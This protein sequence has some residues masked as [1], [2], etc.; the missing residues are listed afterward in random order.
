MKKILSVLIVPVVISACSFGNKDEQNILNVYSNEVIP[1]LD[2]MT[3]SDRYSHTAA[4]QIYEGL[5][6]YHYLKN[7]FEIYPVLADGMP[8]VSNKGLTYTIKLK[9]GV[10]FS[11]DQAFKTTKGKG[12]ELTADDFIYSI[13]RVIVS[14]YT[15]SFFFNS[16]LSDIIVGLEDFKKSASEKASSFSFEQEI[17]GMKALDK[18]TIQFKLKRPSAYFPGILTRPNAFVVAKE[19]VEYY[20]PDFKFHPVGSGPFKMQEWEKETKLT[21]VRNPNYHHGRYPS[22]GAS[23]DSEKG[24]LDD[25]GKPVPFL[26]KIVR[27]ILV[28]EQP[29]WLNFNRGLLDI[30]TLDKDSYYDAFPTGSTLSENLKE[31]GVKVIKT[32]QLDISYYCFNMT[33]NVVGKNKY[34][35]QAISLAYDGNKHNALFFNNQAYVA[36]W[37]LPPD[38]F[39][40]DASYKNPY[41]QFNVE[42]AKKLMVKAGFPGGKRLPP[43]TMLITDSIASKQTGEYFAKSL[44]EIGI[45]VNLQPMNFGLLL[46]EVDEGRNFHVAAVQWRADLPFPEDF[47]RIFYSKA[48]SPG[49]NHSRFSNAEYDKLFERSLQLA[50]GPEKLRLLNRMRDIAVEQAAIIPLINPVT[51]TLTQPYVY[52]YRPHV[53]VGDMYKYVKINPEQKKQV[54]K[55]FYK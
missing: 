2:P 27:Y 3:I 25:A 13:K 51:I 39:G 7:N 6:E 14:P 52:N 11:D 50:P 41:R 31:R 34:L 49:P 12:R 18:Y 22:E 29:R 4:R 45:K 20:G 35:R 33:D 43:L 16:L 47:L 10:T 54:Q 40:F 38:I 23:G 1:G 48:F 19:A 5:Y 32:P 46:H 36:N 53:L 24:M 26:T 30:V 44:E 17:P 15:R 9:Q 21:L 37:V 8:E 55:K 42:K 28:E